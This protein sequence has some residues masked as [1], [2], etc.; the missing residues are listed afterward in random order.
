ML[1]GLKFKAI[2]KSLGLT[3]G[4]FSKPLGVS[5]GQISAIELGTSNP[6]ETLLTLL[7][8]HYRISDTWW[9]TGEGEIFHRP[10]PAPT[11][12][13]YFQPQ[14]SA[15]IVA[16]PSEEALERERAEVLSAVSRLIGFDAAELVDTYSKLPRSKQK[17]ILGDVLEELERQDVDEEKKRDKIE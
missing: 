12:L 17:R 9:E 11:N 10:P 13:R 8:Q 2:R 3:Q 14:K 5:G 16:D 4:E 1:I 6:S 15:G 7:R